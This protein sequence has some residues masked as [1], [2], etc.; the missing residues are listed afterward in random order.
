M[1]TRTGF[2]DE[3]VGYKGHGAPTPYLGGAAVVGAFALAGLTV[4][5]ELSRLSPIVA[6]TFG[7]WCL[8]TIDDRITLSPRLRLTVEFGVASALWALD[9][10]WSVSG[11]PLVDLVITNLWVVGLVNAFNLMDNMDGAAAT[12]AGSPLSPLPRSR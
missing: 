7:L 2:H 4:G 9:L 1:A 11:L 3:P 12:V 5:G 8:G 10:G 6:F